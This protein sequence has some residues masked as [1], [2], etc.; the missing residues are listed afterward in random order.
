MRLDHKLLFGMLRTF[1]IK[2]D[3]VDHAMLKFSLLFLHRWAVVTVSK[4]VLEDLL[5]GPVTLVFER[6]Q[7][8]NHNLNPNTNLVG[9]RIPN[10]NFLRK[11]IRSLGE[12]IALTS[13]NLTNANS[14]LSV[15]VRIKLTIL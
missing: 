3:I 5:P 4:L 10:N 11:V 9:V 1:F 15:D 13:A 7:E 6:T 12:P 2:W 8:L 14:A